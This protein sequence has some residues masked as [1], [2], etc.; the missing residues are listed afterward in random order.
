MAEALVQTEFRYQIPKRFPHLMIALVVV[1]LGSSASTI[2]LGWA[3]EKEQRY[4]LT[5][6][7]GVAFPNQNPIVVY[8]QFIK[9]ILERGLNYSLPQFQQKRQWWNH[10]STT[11]EVVSTIEKLHMERVQQGFPPDYFHHWFYLTGKPSLRVEGSF[12]NAQY[13]GV[14]R[15]L[16]LNNQIAP[17]YDRELQLTIIVEPVEL[18]PG[19]FNL[20]I[21]KVEYSWINGAKQ[22]SSSH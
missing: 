22:S 7:Q 15:M 17:Q 2:I 3:L 6:E 20:K 19:T 12:I 8:H 10:Y 1:C 13:F 5:Q 18:H 16:T 9:L 11:N 14:S 21:R 4:L